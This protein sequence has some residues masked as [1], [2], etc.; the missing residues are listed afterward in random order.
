MQRIIYIFL[1]VL[2]VS[3]NGY[4]Q[5]GRFATRRLNS[6]AKALGMEQLTESNQ[7][8]AFRGKSLNYRKNRWGQ[9]EHL[10]YHLFSDAIRTAQ[11]SP[12]YDFLERYLLEL[13][14]PSEFSTQ[15]R[16]ETDEVVVKGDLAIA[17]T[18]DGTETFSIEEKGLQKY[19]VS[20]TKGKQTLTMAFNKDCQLLT[21]CNAIELEHIISR[22]LQRIE[23]THIEPFYPEGGNLVAKNDSMLLMKGET[24]LSNNINSNIYLKPTKDEGVYTIVED[25]N[26]SA[27]SVANVMTCGSGTYD[28]PLDV[29]LDKYGYDTEDFTISLRQWLSLCQM[30]G[31]KLYWGTKKVEEDRVTGIVLALNNQMAYNHML[32]VS[33]PTVLLTHPKGEV[34]PRIKARLYAYIPL[35][36]MTEKFFNSK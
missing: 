28:Y 9:V 5:D 30:E 1:L 17:K 16:L 6:M 14:L 4:G 32:S 20:W 19:K 21:G 35:H 26:W 23:P 7:A 36:Y 3:L 31:C 12:V 25:A 18:F 33:F 22:N 13:D 8:F 15:L 10:G 27:I 24:Y 34:V 29:K 11:P 2:A